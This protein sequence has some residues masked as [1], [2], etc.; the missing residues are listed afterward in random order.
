MSHTTKNKLPFYIGI[1][2]ILLFIFIRFGLYYL[3]SGGFSGLSMLLPILLLSF[4]L[5]AL[6]TSAFLAAWV[7]QDCKT[8]SGDPA[9]WAIIVFIA[10]PFIG[11][12]TYF[13]HRSEIKTPCPACRHQISIKANYCENCGTPIKKEEPTI[14]TKHQTHHLPL[15]IAG[16]ISMV[17]MLLSLTSFIASAATG[18]GINTD[19]TSNDRVWNLGAISMNYNT[20]QD[21]IWKLDFKSATQGFVKEQNMTIT[22]AD[23]QLLYANISCD[24][25]PEDATLILWLVQDDTA[26]SIN[27]TT[28]PAPLEYPL[29]DFKNGPLH[30]RLQIN[31][32]QNTI[33][34]IQIQPKTP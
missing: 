20:Y 18:T 28:L 6:S 32:V 31:G 25:I 4:I 22:D 29:T 5:F 8:R 15:I 1:P 34:E 2:V 11:L 9:L 26:K 12:L 14:M 10:T 30:V 7:Y 3:K 27:V 24:T 33:S 21:N 17:L 23:T 13:L 19:I 16:A